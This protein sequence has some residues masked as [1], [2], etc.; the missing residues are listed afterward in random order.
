MGRF[1]R[2]RIRVVL[3]VWTV[4]VVLAGFFGTARAGGGGENV[5]VVVNPDSAVSL[6]VAN[7]YI[8]LRRIPPQ[9]VIYLPE[10]PE[11]HTITVEQFRAKILNPLLQTLNGR[12]LGGQVDYVVYSAGFPYRVNVQSD[13]GQ[14][15]LHKLL[16]QPA[17]ITGLTYLYQ[18]VL[19][20]PP[21]YMSLKSNGYLRRPLPQHEWTQWEDREKWDYRKVMQLFDR[22][23]EVREKLKKNPADGELI[24][25]E[26][27][28]LKKME[29]RLAHLVE[30]HPQNYETRY[31]LACLLAMQEREEEALEAL[32]AA[33]E[34]GW[35]NIVH[36]RRDPD[37]EPLR[38]TEQ[39]GR[40]LRRMQAAEVPLQPTMA[41][42]ATYGFTLNGKVVPKG[43]GVSYLLCT[44]L[45]HVGPH[46]NTVEEAVG[47]LRR[48]AGADGARPEGTVYY[49]KNNNIRSRVR[50]WGFYPARNALRKLGVKAEVLEGRLP[51]KRKDVVGAMVGTARF[52]WA[53]SG[54]TIQPGAICEHLT[55]TGGVMG[56]S[57][58]TLLSDWI[59]AG[60]AGSSGTVTE[61]YG[62]QA[63]FPTPFMHVHYVRGASL[64][65]AFYQSIPGPYQLLIVGDPLCRPW[66]RFP[67]VWVEGLGRNV[68]VSGEVAMSPRAEAPEGAKVLWFE[69]F[70]DG[71]RL[72]RVR[73]G[74]GIRFDTA[75]LE[76]GWHEVRV[77][78]VIDPLQTQGSTIIPFRVDRTGAQVQIR[79][80]PEGTVVAAG[81]LNISAALE[82][83]QHISIYQNTR[84]VGMIEGESGRV[85]IEPELLGD[86]PVRLRPVG[87]TDGGIVRGPAVEFTIVQAEQAASA[88]AAGRQGEGETVRP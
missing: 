4:T 62:I 36:T 74:Q 39:F 13:I 59:R 63:K 35:W 2:V 18:L 20:S 48:S 81:K 21:D 22:L 51:P 53:K 31:N 43:E 26:K 33:V 46:S 17:S 61:P 76:E 37:L 82:G 47:S 78:A 5:A 64:A 16:T 67:D 45:A 8:H 49:M 11:G 84:K 24:G 57:G 25:Q 12:G 10:V 1:C 65:E 56:G 44:M 70:M 68:S 29:D 73:P 72:K 28:I 60:A 54:S 69:L 66:A 42:R 50:E 27:A 40:I 77:V 7:E 19:G 80:A 88:R 86:G 23:K 41:F 75:S 3:T 15:K 38:D 83:A 79:Q 6:R 34:A 55:S 9:N 52:D 85:D 14:K 71:R 32:A 58:Q 87:Q 30:A